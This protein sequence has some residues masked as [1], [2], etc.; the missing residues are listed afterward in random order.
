M[1]QVKPFIKSI[2]QFAEHIYDV[3]HNTF[4]IKKRRLV[5]SRY[6]NSQHLSSQWKQKIVSYLRDYKKTK[7]LM[8]SETWRVVLNLEIRKYASFLD[9]RSVLTTKNEKFQSYIQD[10]SFLREHRD[11][12]ITQ[13]V[14]SQ[15]IDENSL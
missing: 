15:P 12:E 7:T 8:D 9:R 6:L 1:S 3:L 11:K 2:I 13:L 10:W 14:Q 5:A 4:K